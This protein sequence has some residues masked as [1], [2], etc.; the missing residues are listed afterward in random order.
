MVVL[1]MVFLGVNIILFFWVGYWVFKELGLK[2]ECEILGEVEFVLGD[3]VFFFKLMENFSV[4]FKS[5]I[6]VGVK[7]IWLLE[8]VNNDIEYVERVMVF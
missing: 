5:M 1:F 8:E 6:V 2:L 4:S 7:F 3:L